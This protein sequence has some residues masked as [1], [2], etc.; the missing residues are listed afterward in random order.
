MDITNDQNRNQI[1][2]CS[3]TWRSSIQSAKTRPGADCG[4]D[5]ELLIAKFILKLKKVRK[6][7]SP[8]RYDLNQIPYDYGVEVMNRVKGL[9]L[10][11][12]GPEEL[13]TEICQESVTKTIPKE[14]KCKKAEWLSEEPLQIAKERRA[15]KSQGEM[16]IPNWMQG[17]REQQG[18]RRP[19]VISAKKWR[20]TIEW[21]G[22]ETSSR[23]LEMS[24]ERFMQG[25]AR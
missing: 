23:K 12:R 7:T 9:D 5:H 6:I 22:L 20:K 11:D 8:F 16:D 10:V 21:E 25:W 18:D 3:W 1:I 17:S 14:K 24:R 2:V 13:R 15:L 19:S 4:S